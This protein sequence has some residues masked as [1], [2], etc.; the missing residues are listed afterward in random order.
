M[1]V[2]EIERDELSTFA[3]G[4]YGGLDRPLH[5][6]LEAEAK[7]FTRGVVQRNGDVALSRSSRPKHQIDG[8]LQAVERPLA[9]DRE[10]LRRALEDKVGVCD[11]ACLDRLGARKVGQDQAERRIEAC[12]IPARQ[13]NARI[14]RQMR[15]AGKRLRHNA[16]IGGDGKRRRIRESSKRSGGPG[17][18]EV[19]LTPR[20]RDGRAREWRR[21]FRLPEACQSPAHRSRRIG[22]SPS[23]WHWR[24][25]SR[26][27][28][29]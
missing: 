29:P 18:H 17:E 4:L 13:R 3:G 6:P 20:L 12:D 11:R 25:K 26:L 7:P 14:E 8:G 19:K 2:L 5:Q 28:R 22:R 27:R 10:R 15:F 24:T 21:S 1:R 16:A 23:P 9:S